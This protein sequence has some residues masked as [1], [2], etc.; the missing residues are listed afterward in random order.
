MVILKISQVKMRGNFY[1]P[2]LYFRDF[3]T[4]AKNAKLKTRENK[5]G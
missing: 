3:L 2:G 4:I 1:S 5:Y